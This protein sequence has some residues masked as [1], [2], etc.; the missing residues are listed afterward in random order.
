ML[1]SFD[2]EFLDEKHQIVKDRVWKISFGSSV[3]PS[4]L[5]ENGNAISKGSKRTKVESV[6][7]KTS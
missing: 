4:P 6:F 3:D 7:E 2:E 1:G 5:V